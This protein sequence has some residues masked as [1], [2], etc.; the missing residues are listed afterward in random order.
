MILFTVEP[1]T[2]SAPIQE[3]ST[4]RSTL[5]C[6]NKTAS[7]PSGTSSFQHDNVFEAST[8]HASLS[9]MD[10]SFKATHSTDNSTSSANF[11]IGTSL[12]KQNPTQN[13]FRAE[14]PFDESKL[15][16]FRQK[17]LP[18]IMYDLPLYSCIYSYC[19]QWA[20]HSTSL[21]II[22]SM[23]YC[24]IHKGENMRKIYNRCNFVNC[25]NCALFRFDDSSSNQDVYCVQHRQP[26]MVAIYEM[27]ERRDCHMT[28]N[29]RLATDLSARFC[30]T[31]AEPGMEVLST[32][33]IYSFH[34]NS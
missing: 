12:P 3:N 18:P 8:K 19:K 13:L 27:C 22:Q 20:S 15:D 5:I 28:A 29:Y 24:V 14:K 32:E 1:A 9:N 17:A 16:H 31:H 7:I 30:M 21:N 10:I 6:Q 11:G 2:G 4:G 34:F 25:L 33:S 26:G 23:K